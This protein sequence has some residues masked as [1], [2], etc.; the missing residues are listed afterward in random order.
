MYK[1]PCVI[2]V[3]GPTASGKTGLG[4]ELA[5]L[6]DGEIVSADSMQIY[7]GMD[8]ATA[9][10][11][12]GEM[13]GI[14]HH[15][16]SV[17]DYS[18]T[19]NVAEYVSMAKETIDNILKRNKL[20]I[21]VGGTG[22]YIDS[23]LDGVSYGEFDIDNARKQELEQS[24]K[25]DGGE[26]LLELLSKYDE[27][28]AK[29]LHPND[30]SRIIRGILVYESTGVT[31]TQHKA[32]SK[33]GGRP[34][35]DLIIGLWCDDREFLYE[36]IN[37]RVDQMIDMGLVQEAREFFEKDLSR[38]A[39]AAIG[40]KEL[41][42]FFLGEK[43]LED[44]IQNLKQETRRYAKRQ[45]TWFR[46]NDKINFI[47]IDKATSFDEVVQRSSYIIRMHIEKYKP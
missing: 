38:T 9:K 41:Y 47:N 34:Y 33:L 17:I 35:D 14:P 43:N 42:P 36:R 24:A 8:I 37:R 30:Y 16:M 11:S 26:C 23:V 6:F 46:R 32:M 40:H 45:M 20:P 25:T 19:F 4:V 3:V 2:A 27:E 22:L 28:L 44:C 12:H 5:K 21:I 39:R 15:L 18:D 31:L 29:K 1:K 7:K 13:Q 10:P